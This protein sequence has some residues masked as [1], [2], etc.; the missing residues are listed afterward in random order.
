MK[1]KKISTELHEELKDVVA[2]VNCTQ[3][4][5][6]NNSLFS[7]LCDEMGSAHEIL[8]LHTQVRWLSCGRIL[9]C[10][11]Y[12]KNEVYMFL[13]GGHLFICEE[14]L[15]KLSYVVNIKKKKKGMI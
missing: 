6:Y 10:I 13:S 14:W 11:F 5:S 4:S 15:G 9:C 8:L 7:V 1:V 3:S 2:M 12:L